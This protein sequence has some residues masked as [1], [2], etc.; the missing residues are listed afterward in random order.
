MRIALDTDLD[1]SYISDQQHGDYEMTRAARLASYATLST[2]ELHNAREY[3]RTVG[4]SIPVLAAATVEIMAINA[5]LHDQRML[6]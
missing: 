6:E 5:V 1:N 3:W 2:E 4:G